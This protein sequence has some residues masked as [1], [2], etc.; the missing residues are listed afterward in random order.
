MGNS[1]EYI[2]LP[3][4]DKK[5]KGF[6][7]LLRL[8]HSF[9]AILCFIKYF[10]LLYR[11]RPKRIIKSDNSHSFWSILLLPSLDKSGVIGFK[12]LPT[13][14]IEGRYCQLHYPRALR[15]PSSLPEVN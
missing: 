9:V 11:S 5:K 2:K 3:W 7:N 12:P 13:A 8:V 4:T 15:R 6:T 1:D 14:V 10:N